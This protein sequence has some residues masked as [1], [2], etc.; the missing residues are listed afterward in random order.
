MVTH[1]IWRCAE[2]Y[3]TFTINRLAYNLKVHKND[4]NGQTSLSNKGRPQFAFPR[5]M[6]RWLLDH[7]IVIVS[8]LMGLYVGLPFLAPVFMNQGWMELGGAIYWLYSFQCHQLPQRSF[9]MYGSQAMYSLN[10]IGEA[11]QESFDPLVLRQFVGN[12]GMGWKVAW[13]DRMVYMYTGTLIFGLIWWPLRHRLEKLPW[14]GLGLLLMPMF[15]DGSTHFISDLAGLGQGFRYTNSWLA[16]LTNNVFS[17]EFYSGNGL[18]S[19]N[20]WMRLVTGILFGVGVVWYGFPY[21][22]D[23][24]KEIRSVSRG[25]QSR[26]HLEW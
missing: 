3:Y 12:P 23:W 5:V 13:S 2:D 8:L 19:F 1:A 9:F 11:W 17:P 15:L 16:N 6:S 4:L 21:I 24:V 22:N 20:S 14:W 7:W 25:T 18:G 10:E 26:E